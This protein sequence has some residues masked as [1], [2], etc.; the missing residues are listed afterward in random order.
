[1]DANTLTSNLEEEI[2]PGQ[3]VVLTCSTNYYGNVQWFYDG[4]SL[5]YQGSINTTK[6]VTV[7]GFTFILYIHI[8]FQS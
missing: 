4:I 2:C 1:M 7:S 5:G 8:E 3:D 6:D